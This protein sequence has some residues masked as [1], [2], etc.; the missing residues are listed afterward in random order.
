M[1]TIRKA[2]E[3][4]DAKVR[5]AALFGSYLYGGSDPFSDIDLLVV[6]EGDDD[7]RALRS[8]ML[9]LSHRIGRVIHLNSYITEEFERRLRY[10]DY[11]LASILEDASLLVGDEDYTQQL[12]LLR[13]RVDEKS[14]EFN[15]AMG[16]KTLGRAIKS[17]RNLQRCAALSPYRPEHSWKGKHLQ[18]LCIRNSHL[19]LG[20]LLASRRM[21]Q[22]GRVPTLRELLSEGAP[23][24]RTLISADKRIKRMGEVSPRDTE[25]CVTRVLS[26]YAKIK[27]RIVAV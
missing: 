16:V 11:K 10:H 21:R 7:K 6:C 3:E 13:G 25:E 15:E 20:Y 2:I 5:F 1:L 22:T 12:K 24:L 26:E 9:R 14:M 18:T 27:T 23:L 8:E 17:L 19:A 4:S